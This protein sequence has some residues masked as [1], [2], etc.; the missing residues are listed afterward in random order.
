MGSGL[1]YW[2]ILFLFAVF[3][4]PGNPWLGA[5]WGPRTGWLLWLVLFVILGWHDFGP[6][7]HMQ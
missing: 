1:I 2:L 6:P 3:G 5:T 7:V 4:F